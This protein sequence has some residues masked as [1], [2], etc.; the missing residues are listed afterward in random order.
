MSGHKN[1]KQKQ[2]VSIS[3]FFFFVLLC[4]ASFLRF[5]ALRERKGKKMVFRK[6]AKMLQRQ[7]GLRKEVED[8]KALE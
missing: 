6:G 7:E 3:R 4:F 2:F 1:V 8:E 5:V